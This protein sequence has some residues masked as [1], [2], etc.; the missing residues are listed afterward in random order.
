MKIRSEESRSP[1]PRGRTLERDLSF[2]VESKDIKVDIDD[3]VLSPFPDLKS[4]NASDEEKNQLKKDKELYYKLQNLE[5]HP[6][7]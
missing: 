2:Q 1:P 3:A 7:M 6:G 4:I 5:D